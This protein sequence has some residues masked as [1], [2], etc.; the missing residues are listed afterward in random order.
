VHERDRTRARFGD[1]S[2]GS[3]VSEE[4]ASLTGARVVKAFN[5]VHFDVWRRTARYAGQPL[6]VPIAG[7][8]D[9]KAVASELVRD[10]G[11][12]PLD[13]GGVEHAHELEAMAAVIIRL[14]FAG[15]DPLSAFQFMVGTGADPA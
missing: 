1:D 13:A 12:E 10:A 5:Q 14:L 3:S 11:G 8:S 7:D 4:I 9:A 15:A 2:P 6:V